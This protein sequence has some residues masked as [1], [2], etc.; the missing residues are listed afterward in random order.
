VTVADVP[1]EVV[2]AGERAAARLR[3]VAGGAAA[4]DAWTPRGDG[5]RRA[6]TVPGGRKGAG[7][8][9][10]SATVAAP[11]LDPVGLFVAARAAGHD[12]ALWVR[13]AD[14]LAI[15]GVGEAWAASPAGA[16]R[17][18][19]VDGAWM[20][21]AGGA[22]V[23]DDSG[24]ARGTGPLLLGGF[25]FDAGGGADPTW[26]GFGPG[27][28]VLP[29]LS[30]A[31]TP[32]G[33]WLTLNSVTS[34]GSHGLVPEPGDP[35]A[36]AAL[37]ARIVAGVEAAPVPLHVSLRVVGG[38]P[39]AEGWRATVDRY[40][41]AVG[42]GRVD[43]VVLARRLDL[44]ADV[45]VDVGGA[46]RALV[47]AAPEST[48]FAIARGD[49]VFLGAT[50]ERLVRTEGRDARTVAIAGT[51]PRGTDPAEDDALA[52]DL[53][54]SE[55]EREEHAV[56]VR[57]LRDSL[58]PLCDSL[59]IAPAPRVI[60]LRTV[61]HLCTDVAARTTDRN[62][63]LAMVDVLHPTP[64]VGGQ[65]RAAALDLIREQEPIDRGWYAGPL[66]WLD[67]DGDGEF[68]VALRSGVVRSGRVS[69]FAG[70]GI[71][72]DSDP[73]REWEESR[74]KLRVLGGA[75]GSADL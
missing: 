45:P 19:E 1:A 68:V 64:A 16:D 56:V 40:A 23:S 11:D 25:A 38:A 4:D 6:P 10:A 21:L 35:E 58:R 3:E 20:A 27:R 75:L 51:A 13:P 47:A 42:R 70:C 18:A 37:W 14:D 67:R 49:A 66:G 9:L 60:R 5:G 36:L 54:A 8:G 24:R 34:D 39:T 31:R 7:S 73:A 33:A 17:F 15:V 74:I 61:Q 26:S 12:P 59:E 65:P 53:L 32:E 71:V 29:R 28:M 72:A 69:L 48:V 44:A 41:G 57:M 55:K 62:G 30:W 22:R 52:A 46:L 50:P 2:A 63:I 43:K